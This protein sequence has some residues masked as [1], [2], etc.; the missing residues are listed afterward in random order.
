MFSS[1]HHNCVLLFQGKNTRTPFESDDLFGKFTVEIIQQY[2]KEEEVRTKHQSA[3][4]RLKEK[5][6]KEKTKAD[7]QWLEQLKRRSQNKGSDD[8]MPSI[9]KRKRGIMMKLE[10]EKVKLTFTII[11]H[12]AYNK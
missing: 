3:I 10:V 12:V 1:Y 6:L 2:M 11:G 7:L 5:S 9:K 8:V 4:L